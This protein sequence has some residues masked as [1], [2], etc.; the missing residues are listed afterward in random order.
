MLTNDCQTV[1]D[2]IP[3]SVTVIVAP[4]SSRSIQSAVQSLNEIKLISSESEKLNAP[5]LGRSRCLCRRGHWNP[6]GRTHPSGCRLSGEHSWK[7]LG[8]TQ[9]DIEMFLNCCTVGRYYRCQ[10]SILDLVSY[11]K[12]RHMTA[13]PLHTLF[14]GSV[15]YCR[16]C[17]RILAERRVFK[18]S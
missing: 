15:S 12:H 14:G 7:V 3:G 4:K 16:Q 11:C 2:E 9:M 6:P 5:C 8:N 13:T 1:F 10:W 17:T 18:L